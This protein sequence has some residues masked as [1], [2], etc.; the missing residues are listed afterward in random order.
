MAKITTHFFSLFCLA[1]FLLC[2]SSCSQ[3]EITPK[4]KA[5]AS[6]TRTIQKCSRLSTAE[7]HVKKLI[8][9][10]D[11]TKVKGSMFGS[12]FSVK[13]PGSERKIAIPVSATLKAYVDFEN[14][15][16]DNVKK[17]NGKLEITLPDPVVEITST[18]INHEDIKRSVSLFRSNFS[19]EE[20]TNYTKQGREAIIASIPELGILEMAKD[21]AAQTL[22]PLLKKMGYDEGDIVVTFRS[23][24]N[25]SK[26]PSIVDG[27]IEKKKK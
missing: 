26:L 8:L 11:D 2:G 4:D 27:D 18:R 17:E 24:L 1:M 21:N 20:F 6:V 22:I 9:H 7:F 14:F 25:A 13:M 3:V 5:E 16:D 23:D 19:D 15:S 12:K 10:K